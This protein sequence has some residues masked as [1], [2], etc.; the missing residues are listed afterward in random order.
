MSEERQTR[1]LGVIVE[2]APTE[3]QIKA[4]EL[5]DRARRYVKN[6]HI[7]FERLLLEAGIWKGCIEYAK[8][9]S[10]D[11]KDVRNM[12]RDLDIRK[13][14]KKNGF[15]Y[16]AD[17]YNGGKY[18]LPKG[19]MGNRNN[20][21]LSK[22]SA[23]AI[24][25]SCQDVRRTKISRINS[26]I[27]KRKGIKVGR[28]RFESKGRIRFRVQTQ[29]SCGKSA[30][31]H[32][33]NF[34][35]PKR[36]K[37]PKIGM[38]KCKEDPFR[39]IHGGRLTM[40][41]VKKDVDRWFATLH[42][43]DIPM[44]IRAKDIRKMSIIGIDAN[45]GKNGYVLSTGETFPIPKALEYLDKKIRKHQ[46]INRNKIGPW[47]ADDKERR[48][49][50]ENWLDQRKNLGKLHRRMRRLREDWLHKV[51]T[52]IVQKY[53]VVIIEDLNVSGM[54]RSAKGNAE[55]A[56]KN[57]KA[58]AGLNRVILQASFS[59]FRRL[60][61]YKLE[62]YGGQLVLVD[63]F[64]PSS[65][66]CNRCGWK[67][68][69]QKLSHRIFKCQKCGLIENRDRN[70]ARNL[71]RVYKDSLAAAAVGNTGG[72]RRPWT[73]IKTY[74][75]SIIRIKMSALEKP[76][77]GKKR[78]RMKTE[79]QRGDGHGQSKGA[80]AVRSVIRSGGGTPSANIETD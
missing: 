66:L 28:A 79:S 42:L 55:A 80:H 43:T 36:I 27:G 17:K 40:I 76:S 75:G 59:T 10:L 47:D 23:N 63:R 78:R 56:G 18:G 62:Q 24:G 30:I 7:K 77:N 60:L 33:K 46:R 26:F 34:I 54:T 22:A 73:G 41:T 65:K 6:A 74:D 71:F 35:T 49:P 12:W 68:A 11:P 45:T 20:R 8:A 44:P 2:L 25:Q 53:S 4:F 1:S 31:N 64:F 21:W 19:W 5:N 32:N 58:K 48:R 50:S 39:Q 52:D 15:K 29:S 16:K 69:D 3:E 70:S 9:H 61:E 37:I 38:V 51:T 14:L 67:D 72:E 57:V 13:E